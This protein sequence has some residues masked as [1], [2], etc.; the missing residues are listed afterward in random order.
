MSSEP[1]YRGPDR[2]TAVEVPHAARVSA[3]GV[4]AVAVTGALVLTALVRS[5]RSLALG[6]FAAVPPEVAHAGGF[7]LAVVLVVT[8][9]VHVRATGRAVA[10]GIGV[11]AAAIALATL[12]DLAHAVGAGPVVLRTAALVAA[13]G[14]TVSAV[15]G[16]DVEGPRRLIL[17]T[18]VAACA[19]VAATTAAAV[20][21]VT[22]A[23]LRIPAMLAVSVAW[24]V[25]GAVIA[26]VGRARD[27]VVT[28]SAG[29]P[30][31]IV[32]AELV[33]PAGMPP[34]PASAATAASLRAGGLFAAAVGVCVAIAVHVTGHRGELLQHR[35]DTRTAERQRSERQQEE[36]H[37]LTNVLFVV[38]GAAAA[39]ARDL[40]R[41]PPEQAAA[42]ADSLWRGVGRLRTLLL[43]EHDGTRSGGVAVEDVTLADL[44]DDRAAAARA[45]GFPVT[46]TGA[47]GVVANTDPTAF[48]QVLDNLLLNAARH[49][50]ADEDAP[51]T[52]ALGVED[53]HVTVRVQDRGPGIPAHERERVFE[54]G[55]QLD[56]SASQGQG[57]GLHI[58]RRMLRALDG[59]IVVE[60]TPARGACFLVTLPLGRGVAP[61]Q[62]PSSEARSTPVG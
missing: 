34:T 52:I 16:P 43:D 20:L 30:L 14:I 59:E 4:G 55:V 51:V 28:W 56:A 46:V 48:S 31:T 1:H 61:D 24:V 7:A 18:I 62:M 42:L 41:L 5:D 47:L 19:V 32:V 25:A 15:R 35:A 50:G 26:T 57:L 10:R 60:E 9:V 33:A 23:Q 17:Q 29:I 39:L 44:V 21:P 2:R 49:A 45:R 22:A 36:R 40:G 13:A 37:E 6:S 8:S 3:V 53:R 11:A 27:V 12:V 58:C 54:R 38:D